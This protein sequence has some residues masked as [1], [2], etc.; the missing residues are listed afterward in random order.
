MFTKRWVQ[1]N[2]RIMTIGLSLALLLA[3]LLSNVVSANT[4]NTIKVSPVRIDTEIEP[5]ATDT[6]Q[7]IVT[8]LTENEITLRPVLNDFIAGDE[9]GT[10]ALILDE[11]QYAPVHS[12]KRFLQPLENVTIPVGE[13][14]PID[15]T[16]NVPQDA[17]AGGYFGA[18]RFAPVTPDDGGQV[19]M[20]ASAASLVLLTVPGDMVEK[21]ELT[22]FDIKQNGSQSGFF[23]DGNNLHATIRFENKGNAQAGPIGKVSVIKKDKVIFEN[24]FNNKNPRDMVLPNSARQWDVNLDN[25]EGFGKY[26]VSATLTYGQSNQSVEVSKTFWVIPWSVIIAVVAGVV[27]LAG[28]IVGAIVMIKRRRKRQA[29]TARG[30]SSGG[31]K[32]L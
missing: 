24:D 29:F 17:Q 20:S 28:A 32:R 26:T 6:V 22:N 13:A 9:R 16:I 23:Y 2:L 11:D 19:N 18:V 14:R 8:N 10:P 31:L 21:L 1:M 25:I 30:R 27:V 15:V 12:L 4:A 5:G 7:V 3:F